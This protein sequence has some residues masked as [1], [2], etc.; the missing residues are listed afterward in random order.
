[1]AATVPRLDDPSLDVR[2]ATTQALIGALRDDGLGNAQDQ[3]VV[4]EALLTLLEVPSFS[5][6]T[7]NARVNLSLVL[8]EIPPAI[9]NRAD[10]R[11]LRARA[12]RASA[13]IALGVRDGRLPEMKQALAYFEKANDNLGFALGLNRSINVSFAV[14]SRSEIEMVRSRLQAIGW[15]LPRTNRSESTI[16]INEVRYGSADTEAAQYLVADIEALGY[17]VQSRPDPSLPA[18]QLSI[19]LR[20]S[21]AGEDQS[22]TS[23]R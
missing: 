9:W 21:L 23:L 15:Y 1:M 3:R 12:R 5:Q 13:E 19:A 10:M 4:I 18:G 16:G 22:S 6:L 8:S 20:A 11:M 17:K 2:R 7:P 14:M